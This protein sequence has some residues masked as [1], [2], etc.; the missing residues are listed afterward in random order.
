[1]RIEAHPILNVPMLDKVSFY[2]NG[3]LI[4]AQKGEMISSALIANGVDIFGHHHK[5][6]SAQGLFCANGQCAKCTVIANGVAVKSCM[7]A[8]EENMIV[9]SAEGLPVLPEDDRTQSF[10]PIEEI[11]CDV[12]I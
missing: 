11:S 8:V 2:F 12:L 6:G 7:T 5:D 3:K 4:E 1:F 10:E 9:Q